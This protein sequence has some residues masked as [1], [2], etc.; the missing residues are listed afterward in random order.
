MSI[1]TSTVP[2]NITALLYVSYLE[3]RYID[4]TTLVLL[5]A[6]YLECITQ[7]NTTL[8]QH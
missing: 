4:N 5:R 8:V 6:F 3:Y 7:N 2:I 1:T